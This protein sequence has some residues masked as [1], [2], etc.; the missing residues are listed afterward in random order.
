MTNQA[1]LRMALP[2][3]WSALDKEALIA[4]LDEGFL[5][6]DDTEDTLMNRLRAAETHLIAFS[7]SPIT[8]KPEAILTVTVIDKPEDA[9]GIADEH[10]DEWMIRRWHPEGSLG[11]ATD[12]SRAARVFA[13]GAEN[14]RG[15]MSLYAIEFGS[16]EPGATVTILTKLK[17]TQV[18][19]VTA[20]LD[21]IAE[22]VSV[23]PR[24]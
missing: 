10:S 19:E 14:E 20:A 6:L 3:G 15:M 18:D 1:K 5:S 8:G 12:I 24:S 11:G 4:A 2:P 22:T 9:I 16:A 13:I 17:E 21:E 23:E 7:P